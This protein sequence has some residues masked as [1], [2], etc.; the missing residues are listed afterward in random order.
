MIKTRTDPVYLQAEKPRPRAL[1]AMGA[2][3]EA[4]VGCA[5]STE[6]DYLGLAL[7][8][9][10]LPLLPGYLGRLCLPEVWSDLVCVAVLGV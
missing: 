5:A 10:I 6:G 8:S 1:L 3:L 7:C 2:R 4:M 9:P